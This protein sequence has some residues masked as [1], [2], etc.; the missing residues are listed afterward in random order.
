[1]ARKSKKVDFVNVG[2]AVTVTAAKEEKPIFRAGLYARLSLESDANKERG[3]IENQIGLLKKFVEGADDI[4]VEREYMDVSKTGTNFERAGF[5]EMMRD[6]RDGRI[7][8]VIVKDLSRL[9]RNYVEAGNY[10]ERVFPF[11]EVRFIAVT[12]GYDSIREGADLS[13]CMSNIFNEF[14]SRDLAKKIRASYRA[15]WKCGSNVSGN[16]AY[17]LMSD[18]RDR[19][20]IIADPDTAP[21]VVRIFEMFVN[22]KMGYAQIA[23]TLNDDGVIG[24]KAY[25]HFKRTKELPVNYNPEWRGGT[26]SR[27]L[28]NPYYAG[29][30][31]HNEY[32][33]DGFAEKRQWREPE[34]N[35][36]IV[37]DTHEPIVPR[38]LYL[39]AQERL[40]EIHENS[41]KYGKKNEGELAC[42]NFYKK[43][44]VCGDCGSTMYLIKNQNGATNFV[45]GGHQTK[46]GCSRKSICESAVNDEVLRVIR[47]HTNVYVDSM[48]M[49]RRMNRKTESMKKYDV[50][51]KEIQRL[52]HEI[53]KVAAHRQHLYEDY[54]ERLID[55]EQYGAFAD[56]DA[57]EEAELRKKLNEV[58]EYQKK[59]DRN[60]CVSH[61]WEAA[62]EKYRNIRHLTKKMV[63]AFVEKVE[64]FSAGKV[65]VHLV[66]DDMLNELKAYAEEREAEDNER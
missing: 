36:I 10:V 39:K 19:H 31:R 1:M 18:P 44:I 65:T 50:L 46:K 47:T 56:R 48:E 14:Y 58:T 23:K 57:A 49:L 30:S 32:G 6:I 60:Y 33:R 41:P 22:D 5:E 21:V 24:P 20:H 28:C 25:K 15:N 2:K 55:A 43:K 26:V 35:W 59:Y 62:I 64:I 61:D 38:A 45:C 54:A 3:T 29:D 17:G 51:T 40:K 63:D 13:V 8:C 9:G 12:D 7:N 11:F 52:Y 42:R 37:E 4:V 53:E 34:E 66:Y 16:L 27:M